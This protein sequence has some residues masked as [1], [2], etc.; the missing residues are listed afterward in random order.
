MRDAL[1]VAAIVDAL[2]LV[3]G[4]AEARSML[5]DGMTLETLI[6]ALPHAPLSDRDSDIVMLTEQR[7]FASNEI[8]LRLRA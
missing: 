5:Q 6:D 4:D 2:R 7:A 1:A 3:H 8:H